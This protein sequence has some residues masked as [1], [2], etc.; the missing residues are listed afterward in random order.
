MS[1]RNSPTRTPAL[2][3]ANRA[4]ALKS[5]GPRTPGGK[6][7]VG[8]NALRHGG[9]AEKLLSF[10]AQADRAWMARRFDLTGLAGSAGRPLRGFETHP[11]TVFFH[12]A[13]R[14]RQELL[15]LYRALYAAFLPDPKTEVQVRYVR[16]VAVYVWLVK[17]RTD[18][19]VVSPAWRQ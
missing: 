17:R 8:L 19:C 18:R 11:Y 3:A 7:R 13:D 14:D 15:C 1:L 6:R 4:N 9:R 12:Q 16:R 2:L 10:L 5:T